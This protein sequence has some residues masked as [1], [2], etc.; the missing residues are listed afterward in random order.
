MPRRMR[1]FPVKT[2]MR[3]MPGMNAL[4]APGIHVMLILRRAVT[5]ALNYN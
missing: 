2:R 4:P 1:G 5:L 3:P